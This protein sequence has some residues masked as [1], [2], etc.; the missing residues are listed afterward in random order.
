M[1]HRITGVMVIGAIAAAVALDA[2]TYK[3]PRTPWGHP[4]LQGYWTNT[5]TTPLQRPPELKDKAQLSGAE[6]AERDRVVAERA[7]QD[8]KPRPGNPG[9]YNDF[10]YERGA[11]NS[12]TSL[13]VDPPDGRVPSLSDAAQKRATADRQGRGPSDGP[14][15]RSAFER[16][17]TRGLPGAMLPGF[18]N[19]NYHIM[20]T[21]DFVV[22]NVE[23]VHDARIVPLTAGNAPPA[24]IRNW[25]GSSRGHWE[26]DTL[27]VQTTNFNDKVREQSLIAFSSGENLRLTERFKRTGPSSIDYEFTV[28]DPAFYTQPWTASVPMVRIDGPIFEYACHEGNY[29]MGGILK[30]ARAEEQAVDGTANRR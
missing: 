25:M 19:H 1:H 9:T 6:L 15:D 18:Y 21:R 3:T 28:D 26:G 30:G 29:G 4:D 16:C 13:V 5:T 8:A 17:I 11:L 20:Q 27:V 14:E 10:W 24:A 2:Q 12:R 23:M 22:I 7:N